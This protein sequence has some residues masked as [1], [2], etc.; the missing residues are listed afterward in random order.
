[1]SWYRDEGL[2]YLLYRGLG[3]HLGK[4]PLLEAARGQ[5][6]YILI[7]IERFIYCKDTCHVGLLLRLT[8]GL[9]HIGQ[10]VQ[11]HLPNSLSFARAS[12]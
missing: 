5:D 3:E 8:E 9:E 2:L 1:M 11:D 7:S 6:S 10:H 12:G 4:V